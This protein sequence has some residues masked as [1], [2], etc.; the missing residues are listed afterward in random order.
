MQ[1]SYS[2]TDSPKSYGSD[3]PFGMEVEEY[4]WNADETDKHR[5]GFQ[6]QET[7]EELWGGSSNYKYRMNDPRIGRFFAV[8]PLAAEYSYN[9]PYAFSENRVIDGIELEGAEYLDA[10][11]ANINC[12]QK[13]DNGTY[14]I[15]L[16]NK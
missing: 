4:S 3:Y 6:N 15:T 1:Y 8:D 11:D 13:N 10:D 9:S 12:Q 2:Y 7:D 5:F 16:G 14:D